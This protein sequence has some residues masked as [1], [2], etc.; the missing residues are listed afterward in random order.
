MRINLILGILVLLPIVMSPGCG[1][2]G[3]PTASVSALE[4][5]FKSNDA[6]TKDAV[7]KII[8]EI[9]AANYAGAFSALSKLDDTPGL[10]PEQRKVVQTAL[11]DV[12]QKVPP[13]P[14][15]APGTPAPSPVPK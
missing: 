1:G 10:T 5:A 9:K 11:H 4:E 7:A 3:S 14:V 15:A 6:T 8:Q 12:A 13:K 2:S